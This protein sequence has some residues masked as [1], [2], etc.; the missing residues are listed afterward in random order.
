MLRE[1]LA[2]QTQVLGKEHAHAK[3]IGA[4]E[5]GWCVEEKLIRTRGPGFMTTKE[6]EKI[7]FKSPEV[8]ACISA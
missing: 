7:V 4:K 5:M 6:G 2:E 3:S 8:R 1:V